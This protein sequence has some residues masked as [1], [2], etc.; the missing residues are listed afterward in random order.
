MCLCRQ[1][2]KTWKRLRLSG[3]GRGLASVDLGPRGRVEVP[4]HASLVPSYANDMN[5]RLGEPV[6]VPLF[7]FLRVLH[8]LCAR[9]CDA[10]A[11]LQEVR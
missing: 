5:L 6:E 1:R 7:G 3:H 10:A 9:G 8:V 2:W 11:E 4:L